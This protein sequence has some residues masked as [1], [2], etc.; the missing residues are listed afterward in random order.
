[1]N[2]EEET[3]ELMTP[4]ERVLLIIKQIKTKIDP[5]SEIKIIDDLS[6]CLHVLAS[7]NLYDAELVVK[8]SSGKELFKLGNAEME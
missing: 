3:Y 6:Y 2:Q 4:L 8:G 7:N 5:Y 1:M